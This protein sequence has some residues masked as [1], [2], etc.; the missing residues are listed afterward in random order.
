MKKLISVMIV[1]VMLLSMLC[2]M[3]TG[4]FANNYKVT[5]EDAKNGDL[6]YEV[7]F[8][9][10]AGVYTP[11][12]Y[13]ASIDADRTDDAVKIKDNG[14]TLEFY[15]PSLTSGSTWYGG[16]FDG[17]TWGKGK[18]YT[19]TMKL[20]LP[21]NRGGV[22]FNFPSGTKLTEQT[23][24]GQATGNYDYYLDLYGIYGKFEESGDL[25]SMKGGGRIDGK[26]RFRTNG[27]KEFDPICV[28]HGTFLNVTFLIEDYTYAVFVDGVFL[29]VIELKEEDVKDVRD[30]LGLSVYL[31]HIK[32]NTPMIIKD[33]N[34]YKGDTVS[35]TAEYPKYAKTYVHYVASETEAP[36]TSAK[37]AE[38]T[39]KLAETT[40]KPADTTAKPA[41]TTAKPAGTTA[42]PTQSGCGSMVT[43]GV[44]IVMLASLAG[45]M[46]QKRKH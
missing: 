10:T 1:A 27:Y 43:G 45:V 42:A 13:K 25:G 41:D 32:E 38:T 7:V 3:A 4:V 12:F 16:K 30:N 8:G 36:D 24:A 14:R 34:V 29:D 11:T 2:T 15:K 5:Y 28:P 18:T 26:Y 46:V 39:A 37:P 9:E 21:E 23:T 17:L 44:A 35:A 33:V 20:S 19:I 6:L 22:Y 40:A 31:Y